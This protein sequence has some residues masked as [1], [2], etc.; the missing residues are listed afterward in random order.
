MSHYLFPFY[1]NLSQTSVSY[2]TCVMQ[3]SNPQKKVSKMSHSILDARIQNRN[4]NSLL[5]AGLVGGARPQCKRVYQ[6]C[7]LG[8]SL[9]VCV[10][11]GV[12]VFS[13]NKV[14]YF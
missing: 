7:L 6:I 4:K 1:N 2:T 5:G 3:P 10:C 13:E 14:Y 12:C 11:V 9:Y 8:F